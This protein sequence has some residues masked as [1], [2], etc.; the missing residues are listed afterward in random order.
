MNGATKVSQVVDTSTNNNKKDQLDPEW[1]TGF[2]DRSASFSI[3]VVRRS[4]TG[5]WEIRPEFI[6]LTNIRHKN[7]LEQVKYYFGVGAIYHSG[8]NVGYRVSSVKDLVSVIIPHFIK[9]PL[10]STKVCTFSL[11]SKA[12]DIFISGK[13][14]TEPGFMEVLSIYAG[15]NRGA[16]ESVK[17]HFPD[18]KPATLP[19]YSLNISSEE[20]SEWWISGYFTLYC[21][22]NVDMNPHGFNIAYYDR[23]VPSFSFSRDIKELPIITLLASYFG[24]TP[25]LRSD[26]LRA[27]VNIYGYNRAIKI[28]DLFDSFPLLSCKQEEFLI[29]AKI[30]Y[31]IKRLQSR[32]SSRSLTHYMNHFIDLGSRLS[33]IRNKNNS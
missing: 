25:N 19:S 10:L 21:N 7:I 18:L 2:C 15:I 20:L 28:V 3:S 17:T 16:S 8:K 26:G 13:H 6:I 29:W 23:V 22:F 1:V 27:D 4:S 5:R 31:D 14:K 24:V 11:W 30:V 9:Y 12:I 33:E 32:N